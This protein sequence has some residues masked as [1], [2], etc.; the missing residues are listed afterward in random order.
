MAYTMNIL[1]ELNFSYTQV[2]GS[3]DDKEL[4]LLVLAFQ[5]ET[6]GLEYV[7]EIL[8]LRRTEDVSKLTVEGLLRLSELERERSIDRDVR[9]VILI[10][11]PI[12][13]QVA[14]V[15]ASVNTRGNFT[16]RVVDN[17]DNGALDWFGYDKVEQVKLKRF[18]SKLD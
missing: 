17:D 8:D 14:E 6:K 10:K 5:I 3:L 13:K 16:V 2:T 9:M 7:R 12:I 1:S 11:D 18:I 4:H 15:F